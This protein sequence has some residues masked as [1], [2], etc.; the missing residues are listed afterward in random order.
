VKP[1]L[2]TIAAA[3]IGLGVLVAPAAHAVEM[4]VVKN[5]QWGFSAAYPKSWTVQQGTVGP[6]YVQGSPPPPEQLVNCNTTA[7]KVPETIGLTQAQINAQLAAP[8]GE[9]FWLKT[10]YAQ[11]ADVKLASQ[12][13]RKHASGLQVQEA[14]V[15]FTQTLGAVPLRVRTRTTI[16][17]TP[18]STFS[19]SCNALDEKFDKYKKEFA[20]I[21]ESFRPGVPASVDAS[22]GPDPTL[23]LV[24]T[25]AE[26]RAVGVSQGVSLNPL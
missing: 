2:K 23:M 8:V 20:A 4:T 19:I 17:V 14:F 7:G 26:K 1:G 24:A 12:V 22:P 18:G 16:F 3:V 21:V 9:E 5:Q 13:S 25:G 10:V 11:H 15:S 6:V